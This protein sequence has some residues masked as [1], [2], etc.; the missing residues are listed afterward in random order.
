MTCSAYCL[1][2][3]EFAAC[4]MLYTGGEFVFTRRGEI[5]FSSRRET[6]QL[7]SQGSSH[8]YLKKF[9]LGVEKKSSI[10]QKQNISSQWEMKLR[11]T[12]SELYKER[13]ATMLAHNV[14]LKW[15]NIFLKS[16]GSKEKL[17]VWKS[18]Q[19]IIHK[20]LSSSFHLPISYTAETWPSSSMKI[21]K[22]I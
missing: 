4:F 16:L 6:L 7:L 2:I 13:K 14:L 5:L 15:Q 1:S 11:R 22:E 17:K 12:S 18:S 21:N 20:I 19:K 9:Q 8:D 3:M 10:N